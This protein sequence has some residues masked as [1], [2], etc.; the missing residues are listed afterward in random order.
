M[1][2]TRISSLPGV[3]VLV[4]L[5][6]LL[7]FW[8]PT[9]ASAQPANRT[10]RVLVL[11]WDNK[12]FPGNIKFDESFKALLQTN[13]TVR[14]E[15]YP[16]YMETTRF[17]GQSQA[18][19][20]DYL[21][22]KY[23]GRNMDVVVATADI[24]LNFLL[25]YRADLFATSPIVFVAN[26]PPS[27]E[28]LA[29]GPGATGIIHQSTHQQTLNLALN[30]HPD[31][32][33]VFVISGSPEHDKRFET[34]ARQELSS[35]ENKV[36]L[37][38]LTDLSLSELI[39][40]TANL[41]PRS[42]A[43]YV[44]QQALDEQGR[45][46][47]TYEVLGRI[48]P[49]SAVPIYGMGSGNIGQ[50]LV[51]GY[52]QGP[53][54]N[55]SQ[56]AEIALR[57]LNGA[58]AQ[59]I[60]VASAPTVAMFDWRQLKRWGI[61]ESSLP[62]NSIIKFREVTF[63][64][65]YKWYIVALIS[66]V[67]IEG[68]LI[69]RLLFTQTKRRQA[70][71]ET[72]R[73]HEI[74]EK[75]H[76]RLGEIV[77]N[78]PGIVWE[79][80]I[81]PLTKER[82][83]TFVSNHVRKM[84]GF[85]PR[86]WLESPETARALIDKEDR[87]RT[88][89]DYEAVIASGKDGITQFRLQTKDGQT[90]WAETH[91]SPIND[92]DQ[93]IVGL[94]GVT[95][96]ITERKLAEEA[97]RKTEE[98]DRAILKAIPDL[99]F[100]QTLDGVYLD[101]HAKD[102]RDLFAPPDEFLG[103]N[104]RAILPAK[105]AEDFAR[106]FARAEPFGEPQIVEYP[107]PL[108]GSQRWFEA[109]IVR[110]GENILSVV[111][112]VTQRVF[113]E[114]AIKRNEAQLAG[115]IG[116]A[117]DAIITVDE[118]QR[119]MLFN[120]AAEKIFG[121][122]VS[123]AIGQSLDLFIPERYRGLHRGHVSGFG[124]RNVQ[125]RIMGERGIEL[126]GLR[127]SGEEFPMEASISQIELSGQKFFTVILRDI[128]ER[129]QALDELRES[130]E[131]FAK[132]FQANPQPM[133]LTR[134]ADGLYL[135]ANESF[136]ELSGYTRD[137]V[138]GHTSIELNIWETPEARE[139]FIAELNKRGSVVNKDMKFRTKDGSFRMFLSSGERLELGGEE[140]LLV[141]S[142]DITE[143]MLA[144]QAL[145]ESEARFRN[146]AETA[147]VMIW[148]TDQYQECTYVNKRWLEFTGRPVEKELGRGWAAVI[149]RD[150]LE[151]TL[152]SYGEAFDGRQPVNLEFRARR[153]DGKYRWILANG[154]PRFS[155]D[156]EFL[157][158]IGSCLDITERR[159]SEQ[160]L[161][162]AHEELHEL[163]NQLEA[164][165]IYL[166]EELRSDQAFGEIVG[167]S[168]AIRYVLFKVSQVALTDSTVLITGE[169]G[170]GKELVARAIHSSSSRK[171]RPLIRVNCAALPASLI[172]SEL[173]GHEKGAFTGAAGRKLGRFELANGGTIFLDEI[174]ELPL[175]SQV[176]LLRVIQE[177]E[178]E[179]LGSAKTIRIDVRIMAATNRNL[180]LEVEKGTFR[181]DLWYRLNVFPIT[182]PPLR[183]RKPDIPVLV[184]HFVS[185]YG[186]K[187]GK[188]ITSISPHTMQNLER[189]AWPGNVR[190]L[191][192]VI[193]RA[194]IHT[195]GNVLH[196]VDHFEAAPQGSSAAAKSL[197]EVE[198]E[199]IIRTLENTGWRIEGPHG[200]A[201][202]L[203]LNPSTLRTRMVKLGIHKATLSAGR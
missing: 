201:R 99:M 155:A 83:P 97:V 149:H 119:I 70:E 176:R 202:T 138:I 17:P 126:Y 6:T 57:I 129:K 98:K 34:V 95:L 16:E 66:A 31:T 52:L 184:E 150:D 110:S 109:R 72:Q 67:I 125:Q 96:D 101:Y 25:Q 121:W 15:Y 143:R 18:F 141:A 61:N 164:E 139:D 2:T 191:A 40:R 194:V 102:Q 189:H 39:S 85:S 3:S 187:L 177:G 192:N 30:L 134:I 44:W 158:Y 182:V 123:D 173:F 168:D 47:E 90:R 38:Y 5:T 159:E 51:G 156:G 73:Q 22:Q 196:L 181:E 116:S 113:T 14:V 154:T 59:D 195:Q 19:F 71:R 60:P 43:L 26:H 62:P 108:N 56:T 146:M 200:A 167:V 169:T 107:L 75:A 148:V 117:M 7:V 9:A 162:T 131:R 178:F 140:C 55:G 172:E 64:Q 185:K 77:S 37:T 112:D 193:E 120:T 203:G 68:L 4:L 180:K 103:K 136:L 87:K 127:R 76:R 161:R 78:V 153:A 144:Q 54:S 124:D 170:T 21:R 186:K 36:S 42:I 58:R 128:T 111:R 24:P 1:K 166:Q 8:W 183:Q 49:S 122:S 105:L 100:L 130:E 145:R 197:E 179:R 81:D 92:G 160:E 91:L 27:A 86:E 28:V 157:G 29:T 152:A 114:E 33:Q 23:A 10:Y 175:E 142:S 190:E 115:I 106:C 147:P 165:N 80:V 20:H 48:S 171:D 13:R 45:L 198:R 69:L 46:L 93:K 32:N 137:E 50:G 104:M 41:P 74:A 118:D 12:D 94:R 188:T 11:F 199:Y 88:E 63:W 174:G 53:D 79:T 35:F 135:D 151:L 89:Q 84:L 65:S 82:K 133:S 132:A 163:K